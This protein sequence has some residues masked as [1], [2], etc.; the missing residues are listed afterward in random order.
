MLM[1][2]QVLGQAQIYRVTGTIVS[3]TN[4]LNLVWN[5]SPSP[6]VVGYAVYWG[7]SDDSCTNRIAL[8]NVT[9]VTLAGFRRR[10]T[11]SLAV[12][13]YDASGEESPW[14]N[15]I[16]YSRP[17]FVM[18]VLPPNTATNLLQLQHM[19]LTGT[20]SV[21]RLSFTGQAD[22]DYQ[23]Q[24]TEDFQRWEVL[25]ATNCVEQQLVVYDLPYSAT[26]AGRFF[27]LVQE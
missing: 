2:G 11:Y 25:C 15:S 18:P 21:L 14:S 12:A 17:P 10:G 24:A 22:V 19:N 6:G 5:P 20:N 13:A 4:A 23:L 9:S 27:R 16:Q 8:R 7:L 3:Q 1:L 26:T